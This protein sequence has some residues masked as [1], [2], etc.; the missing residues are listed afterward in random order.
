M[1]IS[2]IFLMVLISENLIKLV[3]QTGRLVYYLFVE[4]V[5]DVE[6]LSVA[7]NGLLVD[8]D[9]T[10]HIGTWTFHQLQGERAVEVVLVPTPDVLEWN[11]LKQQEANDWESVFQNW[12]LIRVQCASC[13]RHNS[14]LNKYV[15]FL[16]IEKKMS[17]LTKKMWI[18]S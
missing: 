9:L 18:K 1:Q 11:L 4:V 6:D 15:L 10:A 7:Q 17:S 3:P 13:K 8:L 5:L 2:W 12:D 14:H 16:I